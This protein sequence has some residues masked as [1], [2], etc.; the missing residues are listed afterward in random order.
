M[1]AERSRRIARQQQAETV[2]CPTCGAGPGEPCYRRT[3]WDPKPKSTPHRE[4][5][6]AAR[7]AAS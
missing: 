5:T 3:G 2:R 1:T 7:E 4:R 6:R